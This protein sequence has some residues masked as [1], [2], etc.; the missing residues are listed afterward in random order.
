M[1]LEILF[2][3]DGNLTNKNNQNIIPVAYFQSV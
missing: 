1:S 3:Q 2:N